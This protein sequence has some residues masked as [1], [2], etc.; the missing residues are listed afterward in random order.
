MA[1]LL[2]IDV[3]FHG[4]DNSIIDLLLVLRRAYSIEVEVFFL[5]RGTVK[6]V[7]IVKVVDSPLTKFQWQAAIFVI[8]SFV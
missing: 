5:K 2:H 7:I 4:F 1:V 6:F 8:D 3:I